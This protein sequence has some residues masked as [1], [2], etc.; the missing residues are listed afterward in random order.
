M[1]RLNRISAEKYPDDPA[2]QARIKSYE[3]AF[4]M[5]T[6]VPEVVRLEAETERDA[7][8]LRDRPRRLPRVRP[9]VP[10]GPAAG[11]ARASGSSSSSTA[12]GGAGAWDAHEKLK[13]NHSKLCARSTG[14][15]AGLLQDLK[16]RGLL[17]E[18]IVVWA[19]EFGRTPGA[20][21]ADGRDHHPFGF[22]AWMAGGGIK[23][24]R[25]PRRD[26]RARLPRRRSTATT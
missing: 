4:R 16:R 22:P 7:A 18:T 15:I 12:T 26:R 17:D 19:S 6:A 23:G 11:R 24:G 8:P 14:P 13:E 21:N 25:R 2:L 5:Q 9:P 1:G 3:L 20:Q 10:R